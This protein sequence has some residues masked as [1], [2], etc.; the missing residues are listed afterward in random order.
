MGSRGEW[1]WMCVEAHVPG[2]GRAGDPD[3]SHYPP[4]QS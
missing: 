4:N 2:A 1:G 3:Q